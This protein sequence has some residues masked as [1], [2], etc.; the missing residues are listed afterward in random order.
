[1]DMFTFEITIDK[2]GDK[3]SNNTHRTIP[4]FMAPGIDVPDVARRLSFVYP[5]SNV[6]VSMFKTDCIRWLFRNGD[7]LLSKPDLA[8]SYPEVAV[9]LEDMTICQSS[10]T[11]YGA[12]EK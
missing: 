7:L 8:G 10:W 9:E 6:V 4:V 11:C 1:M 3:F 5:D 12:H 2:S